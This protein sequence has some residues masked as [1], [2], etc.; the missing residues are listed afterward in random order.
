MG[1]PDCNFE[2]DISE[3]KTATVPHRLHT[4]F[5]LCRA[6]DLRR[7]ELISRRPPEANDCHAHFVVTAATRKSRIG[8]AAVPPR[9]NQMFMSGLL[10][11]FPHS[12]AAEVL[13][14]TGRT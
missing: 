1:T 7:V 12:Y 2:L 13:K 3:R 6:S 10:K 4:L 9:I 14:Q 11:A 5:N 8:E